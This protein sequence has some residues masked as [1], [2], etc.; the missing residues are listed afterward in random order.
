MLQM[1]I[2][3]PIREYPE[4]EEVDPKKKGAKDKDKDKKKKKR[5]KTEAFPLPDWAIELD[6]VK[7]QV[8]LVTSLMKKKLN[9]LKLIKMPILI[10]QKQELTKLQ[11][12]LCLIITLTY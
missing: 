9:D 3:Y 11:R 8:Q 6:A 4:V 10:L 2:E 7:R 12:L 5:K 1:L